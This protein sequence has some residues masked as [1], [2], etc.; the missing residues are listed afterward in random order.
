MTLKLLPRPT[1]VPTV[2]HISNTLAT[3][4]YN[5]DMPTIWPPKRPVTKKVAPANT[6][7]KFKYPTGIDPDKGKGK[8]SDKDKVGVLETVHKYL[9]SLLT[10][11]IRG[12]VVAPK[13]KLRRSDGCCVS[14][15][16]NVFDG[17]MMR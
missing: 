8:A 17:L 15:G 16:L 13:A 14:N 5:I 1:T 10:W 7:Y 4:P 11:E 9:G 2:L 6:V 3:R 12:R